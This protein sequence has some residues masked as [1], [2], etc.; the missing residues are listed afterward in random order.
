MELATYFNK[1]K[2]TGGL[3]NWNHPLA[4]GLV[5]CVPNFIGGGLAIDLVGRNYVQVGQPTW[6]VR[7][8]GLCQAGGGFTNASTNNLNFTSGAFTVAGFFS[9]ATN[10]ASGQFPACCRRYHDGGNGDRAGWFLGGDSTGNGLYFEC[11]RN[12]SPAPGNS[13]L[14]SGVSAVAGEWFLVGTS[15]GITRRIFVNGVEKASTTNNA[16]PLTETSGNYQCTANNSTN[17]VYIHYAWEKR[18]LTQQEVLFLY[19]N[20]YCIFH[21]QFIPLFNLPSSDIT[22]QA[23]ALTI[24][25]ILPSTNRIITLF[26]DA[27]QINTNLPSVNESVSATPNA[28]IINSNL[29]SVGKTVTKFPDALTIS[30]TIQTGTPKV[31][32]SPNALSM[33]LNQPT[34]DKTV[35]KTPAALTMTAQVTTP[36]PKAIIT[37]NALTLQFILT[38]FTVDTGSGN[39]TVVV[40]A[41]TMSFTLPSVGKSISISPDAQTIQ[42]VL[43]NAAPKVTITATAQQILSILNQADRTINISA[44]SQ[45][46]TAILTD[47]NKSISIPVNALQLQ[48]ILNSFTITGPDAPGVRRRGPKIVNFRNPLIISLRTDKPH[49]GKSSITPKSSKQTPNTE[50]EK[51]PQ[52]PKISNEGI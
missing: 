16:N 20:P 3:I 50:I 23:G 6:A 37:P 14:S 49:S 5:S 52:D 11:A 9:L 44:S 33:N 47:A 1:V 29:P 10:V 4:R 24:N 48:T 2:P 38:N 34:T 17:R 13:I 43:N 35:S 40:G 36:I 8:N 31:I 45:R 27:L 28:Q 42:A 30:A 12:D 41:L 15:N 25:S 22:I 51:K 26:P 19:N 21:P 39:K 18:Q 32:Q 46:I 7:K